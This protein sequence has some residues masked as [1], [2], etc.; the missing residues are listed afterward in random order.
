ML[1]DYNI[2]CLI[3]RKT[4]SKLLLP[5]LSDLIH[6]HTTCRVEI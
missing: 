3:L 4:I 1:G 2:S 6:A 5:G